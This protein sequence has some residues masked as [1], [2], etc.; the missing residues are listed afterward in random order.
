MTHGPGTARTNWF[1]VTAE[2]VLAGVQAALESEELNLY[3]E[4][5][6]STLRQPSRDRVG[7]SS[8]HAHVTVCVWT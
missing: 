4:L 1:H 3:R 5:I 7:T 2:E 6:E 8:L